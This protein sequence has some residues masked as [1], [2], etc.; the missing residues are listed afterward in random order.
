MR[1]FIIYLTKTK[2]KH[3]LYNLINFDNPLNIY[4]APIYAI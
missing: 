1:N 2:F 3:N 4:S